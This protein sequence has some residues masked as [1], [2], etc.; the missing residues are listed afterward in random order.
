[1]TQKFGPGQVVATPGA[2]TALEDSGQEPT[3]FL[4]RHLRGDWGEVGP[5]DC[6][7]NGEAVRDGSRI[8]STYRSLRGVEVWVITEAAGNDGRRTSTC[9]LTPGEY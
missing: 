7:A 9:L 1:M 3:F 4:E 2:L 5:G 6:R 8:L